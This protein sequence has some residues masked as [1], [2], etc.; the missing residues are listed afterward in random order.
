M[1][2]LETFRKIPLEERQS[3]SDKILDQFPDRIPV[4]VDKSHDCR[5][6]GLS[7]NKY[8]IPS[9]NSVGS[10]IYEIRKYLSIN[11]NESLI[12]FINGAIPGTSRIMGTLYNRYKDED[13]FLYITYTGENTFG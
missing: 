8:L 5:L 2:F 7:K 6:P 1:A 9:S 3:I 4:I 13:G 12:I 10:F 11:S